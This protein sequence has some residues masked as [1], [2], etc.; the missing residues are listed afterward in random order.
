MVFVMETFSKNAI[1]KGN[2][3]HIESFLISKLFTMKPDSKVMFQFACIQKWRVMPFCK[4]T[5]TSVL[6]KQFGCSLSMV[7]YRLLHTQVHHL[8]GPDC[9]SG[10]VSKANNFRNSTNNLSRY[11]KYIIR[12][13][14]R[15]MFRG[16]NWSAVRLSGGYGSLQFAN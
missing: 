12:V 7:V 9:C 10:L 2:C 5:S 16:K 15:K 13:S 1:T 4:K 6:I 11:I 3:V 8:V 14:S